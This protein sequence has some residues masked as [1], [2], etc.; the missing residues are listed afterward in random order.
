MFFSF[1]IQIMNNK[2]NL[3]YL[4]LM[5]TINLRIIFKKLKKN[6]KKNNNSFIFKVF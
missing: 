3:M 5:K 2:K 1:F 4:K 6:E